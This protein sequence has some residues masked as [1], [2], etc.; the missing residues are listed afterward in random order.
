MTPRK[1]LRRCCH[2]GEPYFCFNHYYAGKCFIANNLFAHVCRHFRVSQRGN[3]T[4]AKA[5]KTKR[6]ELAAFALLFG[7]KW[8]SNTCQVPF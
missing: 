1:W 7:S 6:F 4:V 8:S 2:D 5:V 3:E